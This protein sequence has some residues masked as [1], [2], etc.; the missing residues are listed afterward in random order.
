VL[1]A[2]VDADLRFIFVDVGSNGRV[3]DRGIWNR[4]EL[5]TYLENNII[6][7]DPLPGTDTLFPYVVI[8]DEGFSL[9]DNVL[10]PYP[11]ALLANRM[12]RRIFNYR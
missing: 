2:L 7:S 10:I 4:C 5:K 9:S 8:G 12:D 1:L 3:S 11:R 6:P